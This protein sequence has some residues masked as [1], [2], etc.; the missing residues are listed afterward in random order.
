MVKNKAR[1]IDFN[2]QDI[3]SHQSLWKG[4][5]SRIWQ[6]KKPVIVVL[7]WIQKGEPLYSYLDQSLDLEEPRKGVLM[8]E[9]AV[10]RLTET[11]KELRAII[12]SP[13]LKGN[14][15]STSVYPP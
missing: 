9:A 6:R 2:I 7:H 8:A 4:G 15:G 1:N 3:F 12:T 14:L 10:W 5:D 13:S 11:L